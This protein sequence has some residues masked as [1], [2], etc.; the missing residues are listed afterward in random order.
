[1]TELTQTPLFMFGMMCNYLCMIYG[2]KQFMRERREMTYKFPIQLYNIVQVF[3][4]LYIILGLYDAYPLDNFYGINLVYN[5]KIKYYVWLHYMSKY[6]DYFD[7]IFMLLRKKNSQVTFLHVY[8]HAT[9]IIPWG[10]IVSGGHANGTAG[11]G[12]LINAF[13]HMIMYSHYFWTSFGYRNP[14]K[15]FITQIQ[16]GQ[17]FLCSGHS[18][19]VI[20]YEKYV[21][22]KYACGE[23][24]YHMQ[25]IYLFSN[26]YSSSYT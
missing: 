11:F 22:A 3:Y 8:H 24:L 20:L 12:A 2:L 19:A 18:L 17:F 10:W 16:I 1:M 6:L 4:N 21:P 9:V 14:L 25:M 15:R 26:F 23:I 13:V 7:T 5:D